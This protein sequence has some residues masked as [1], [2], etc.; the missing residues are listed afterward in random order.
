MSWSLSGQMARLNRSIEAGVRFLT[1][2]QLSLEANKLLENQLGQL[3]TF[4]TDLAMKIGEQ[5]QSSLTESLAP[6]IRKLDDMGGDM[7]QQISMRSRILLK[8]SPKG[9]RVRLRAR[10]TGWPLLWIPLLKS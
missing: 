2:E 3:K 8:R 5:V 4:N 9:F 7:A 1:A 10:W 6:V